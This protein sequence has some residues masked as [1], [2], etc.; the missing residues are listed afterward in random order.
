MGL[1]QRAWLVRERVVGE[2]GRSL[3][4]RRVGIEVACG[5]LLQPVVLGWGDREVVQAEPAVV[6]ERVAVEGRQLGGRLGG[7]LGRG[8]AEPARVRGPQCLER[9]GRVRQLGQQRRSGQVTGAARPEQHVRPVVHP[10]GVDEPGQHR[11]DVPPERRSGRR[12]E[13]ELRIPAEQ[14]VD[15]VVHGHHAVETGTEVGRGDGHGRRLRLQ[16]L[17]ADRDGRAHP[18]VGGVVVPT[19]VVGEGGGRFLQVGRRAAEPAEHDEPTLVVGP[20]LTERHLG[21]HE[22][23]AVEAVRRA[24]LATTGDRAR[25]RIDHQSLAGRAGDGGVATPGGLR[26]LGAEVHRVE[27]LV[28]AGLAVGQVHPPGHLPDIGGDLPH[29]LPGAVQPVHPEPGA[30]ALDPAGR[31]LEP[32]RR[33]RRLPRRLGSDHVLVR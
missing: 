23:A 19:V 12:V 33:L 6:A 4:Q 3:P 18:A 20:Q 7:G 26:V 10:A 30:L 8:V 14:V 31:V 29:D 2:R 27:E 22:R 13:R 16:L 32:T 28:P 9:G 5:P 1:V 11:V 24:R 25:T 15:D 17:A 21:P